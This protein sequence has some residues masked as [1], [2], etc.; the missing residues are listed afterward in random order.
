MLVEGD[1]T[2]I[3]VG[4]NIQPGGVCVENNMENYPVDN[5]E[6]LD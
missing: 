3:E 2:F 6:R 4:G 5:N 1:V